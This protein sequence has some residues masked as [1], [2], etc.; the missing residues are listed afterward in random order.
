MMTFTQH[1]YTGAVKD[2][3]VELRA[4]ALIDYGN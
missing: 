2:Y 4:Y 1:K 3:S